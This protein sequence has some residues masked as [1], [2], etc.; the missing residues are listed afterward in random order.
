[1]EKKAKYQEIAEWIQEQI[2]HKEL[3]PGER[4][5]SENELSKMFGVSRQTARHA[6]TA[7]TEQGLV[8]SRRGSGTYI[9]GCPKPTAKIMHKTMRVAVL[10]TY[11][12]EYIFPK[13]LKEMEEVLSRS[14][15]S[16]QIAATNNAV[17]K[18][19][20]LL[21]RFWAGQQIDGIIAETTKSG[22]PNPNVPLYRKLIQGGIPVVFVN[23]YYPDLAAPHVSVKDEAAGELV[24][25]H[26]I[27]CGHQRIAGIFKCDDG[28]G[29]RR[30]AGYVKALMDADIKV[31]GERIVW[32][33]TEEQRHMKEEHG[34][35]L[36][37]IKGCSGCVC[38]NDQVANHLVGICKEQGIVIPDELSVISIDNSDLAVYC[39][40]P[41]TSAINPVNELAKAAA[42][43]L[44]ELMQGKA[45]VKDYE[46]EPELVIRNSVKLVHDFSNYKNRKE[47]K[48][49]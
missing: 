24:T 6:I 14:G 47:E 15:Y 32:I 29:H 3:S 4:L 20:F 23:S 44:M 35:I 36:K 34:R 21:E 43:K 25:K 27:E 37:R 28:Q 30:Y 48:R 10:T 12:D 41:F 49:C 26:L 13:M 16:I 42:S 38:Y 1:M 39:E 31:K 33:D 2:Q 5:Y 17:E 18:E 7:L 40:I 22:V 9:C 19:R 11:V 8:S 46:L 45:T